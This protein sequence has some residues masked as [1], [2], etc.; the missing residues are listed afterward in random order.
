MWLTRARV[1]QKFDADLV[2]VELG[3]VGDGHVAATCRLPETHGSG[4]D[5]LDDSVRNLID[6]EL[7]P[8][9]LRL[10]TSS[11]SGPADAGWE[12]DRNLCVKSKLRRLTFKLLSDGNLEA[13]GIQVSGCPGVRMPSR[14][15][16]R[17][18][19]LVQHTG[20]VCQGASL[21]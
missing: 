11:V 13:V 20:E 16:K 7:L 12:H 4:K 3:P 8:L 14:Q 6:M 2:L 5:D 9:L 10:K 15:E 1:Q 19:P 18:N 21:R 17:W